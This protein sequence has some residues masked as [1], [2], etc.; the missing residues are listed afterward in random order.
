VYNRSTGAA[1]TGNW[2]TV[3]VGTNTVLLDWTAGTNGSLKLTINGGLKQTVNGNSN[4]L[5]I[6]T[7]RLGVI[8]GFGTGTSG[9]GYFDGFSSGRTSAP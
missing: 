5:R 2:Y 4:T 3:A 1:V 6:D 9:T 7:A 8:S